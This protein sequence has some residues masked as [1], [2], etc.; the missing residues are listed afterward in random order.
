MVGVY[1]WARLLPLIKGN[2]WR[3]ILSMGH[4]Q[5]TVLAAREMSASFLDGASG[6]HSLARTAYPAFYNLAFS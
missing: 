3:R 4:Q 6:R 5:A 2:F 1:P